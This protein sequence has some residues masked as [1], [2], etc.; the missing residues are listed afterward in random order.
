MQTTLQ[1]TGMHCASCKKL[2]ESVSKDIPGVQNCE[3]DFATGKAIVTHDE[4]M[5]IQKLKQEILSL[6]EYTVDIF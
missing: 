4:S 2:I 6:G 1:I 5:N 3:V